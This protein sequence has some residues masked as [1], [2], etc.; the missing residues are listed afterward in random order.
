MAARKRSLHL[1][2]K[3]IDEGEPLEYLLDRKVLDELPPN[4]RSLA[5]AITS[6][7]LRRRFQIEKILSGYMQKPLGRRGGP[8]MHLLRLAV[9]QILFLDVADHAAVST[10]MEIA[11]SDHK[12]KH[13]S[14]LI[15][16]VL[17][18]IGRE[19]E[20]ILANLDPID[21]L[22]EWLC[23]TWVRAYGKKT[24]ADMASALCHEPYLDIATKSDP[25]KWAET[26]EGVALPTGSVRLKSRGAVPNLSGF[27]EGEWW[28][29]DTAASLAPS[30]LG[31]VNGKTVADLCAAPGGKTA[32]LASK[33]ALVTAVDSSA[34]RLEKLTENLKRLKLEADCVTNDVTTWKPAQLFDAILLDAPCS[35]TGI[36]RKHPDILSLKAEQQIS[37]MAALQRKILKASV[38]FLK[39]G[40]TLVFCTCSLQPEEG[41]AILDYIET[42]NLPLKLDPISADEIGGVS[43][44]IQENGTIRT[45]PHY[46]E[47][48]D[49]VLSGIDGFFMA[50]FQH[51][52]NKNAG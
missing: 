4:D 27:E 18:T 5:R 45:L 6:T 28:V 2:T 26:L 1:L 34:P 36:V 20:E 10:T 46:L 33:G 44:L 21:I 22:P 47:Q 7:T 40:G 8:A 3:V 32:Y 30:L 48:A 16:G 9:A 52:T 43:Q 38:A 11:K 12:A 50:R 13:F 23:K 31:D 25:K 41:E 19:K 15:N 37:Q 42:E 14:K 39:P 49:P 24:V 17:R 51:I 35:A 29:Q